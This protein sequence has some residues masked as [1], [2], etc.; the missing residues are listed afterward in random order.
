M[1]ERP[2]IK[3]QFSDQFHLMR[4][5]ARVTQAEVADALGV[6]RMTVS[7][8]ETG[9]SLPRL[10]TIE[11]IS[12]YFRTALDDSDVEFRFSGSTTGSRA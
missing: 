1:A 9:A 3:L 8:W 6:S 5:R 10:E 12:D 2:S 4:R 7:T 11:R